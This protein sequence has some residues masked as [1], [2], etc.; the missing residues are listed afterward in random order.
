MNSHH[1]TYNFTISRGNITKK[2][3]QK[4]LQII[5]N[6]MKNKMKNKTKSDKFIK[7]TPAH[8]VWCLMEDKKNP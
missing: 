7:I 3:N 2:E 8:L 1:S 6:V 5:I 4:Y